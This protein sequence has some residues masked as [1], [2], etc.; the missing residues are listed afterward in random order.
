MTSFSSVVITLFRF[1]TYAYFFNTIRPLFL[2]FVIGSYQKFH[3][4]SNGEQLDA[5]QD[6]HHPEHQ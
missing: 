2:R 4:N 5:R 3:Y 6:E 1:A